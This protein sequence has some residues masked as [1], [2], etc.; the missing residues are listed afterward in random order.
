MFEHLTKF[1]VCVSSTI[2]AATAGSAAIFS[3]PAD[4][5]ASQERPGWVHVFKDKDFSESSRVFMFR[6]SYR[7]LRDAKWDDDPEDAG[8]GDDV[9]SLR[10]QIPRG[11]KVQI[12]ENRNYGKVMLELEGQGEIRHLGDYSDKMSSIRWV[13]K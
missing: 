9:T 13:R 5:E 8:M 2:L 11:W 12:C 6:D 4:L 7:N 3:T 1:P 10:Y